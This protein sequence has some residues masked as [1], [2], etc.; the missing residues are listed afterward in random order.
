MLAPL[1]PIPVERV[2]A[3]G[4]LSHGW[5]QLIGTAIH[6][7]QRELR[8]WQAGSHPA[9]TPRYVPDKAA[10]LLMYFEAALDSSSHVPELAQ[11]MLA[12]CRF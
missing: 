12:M 5:L 6:Y 7:S 2:G 4:R 11:P 10:D 8:Q 9:Q 1:R 3:R